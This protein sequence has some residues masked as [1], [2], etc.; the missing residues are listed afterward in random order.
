MQSSCLELEER[1]VEGTRMQMRFRVRR[2][3]DG[4]G[5][6]AVARSKKREEKVREQG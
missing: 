1:R 6:R 4:L 2:R 3:V 5:G